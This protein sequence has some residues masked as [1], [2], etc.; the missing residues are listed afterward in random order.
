VIFVGD[1]KAIKGPSLHPFAVK[2]YGVKVKVIAL[3]KGT[4]ADEVTFAVAAKMDTNPQEEAPKVNQ[5]YLFFGRSYRTGSG[6]QF[7]IL[8]LLPAD[9]STIARVNQ[10]SAAAPT[11][12]PR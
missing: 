7:E 8:K 5:R 10:L 11:S 1:I 6:I 3:L 9:E 4:I 12:S 2:N